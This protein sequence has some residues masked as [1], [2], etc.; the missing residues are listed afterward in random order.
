MEPAF[1]SP[2]PPTERWDLNR[3]ARRRRPGSA[4]PWPLVAGFIAQLL[5]IFFVTGVGLRELAAT[6]VRLRTLVDQHMTRLRLTHTMQVAV[7]ERTV[8]LARMVT[9]PDM[10]AQDEEQQLL[11]RQAE[12]FITARRQLLA[13][14]LTRQERALLD[15][16]WQLIRQAIPL[17]NQVIDLSLAGHQHQ[18]QQVLARETIPAQDAVMR[19]LTQLDDLIRTGAHAALQEATDAHH[20]A[21][22]WMLMLSAA[23]LALG[24]LIAGVVVRNIH[25]AN[26]ERERLATH[27]H[28]TGLPNR[29]LLLDRID[30]A[31]LRARRQHTQVGLLFIDLDGF[32][33]INDTLG[34]GVGDEMLKIIAQRLKGEVRAGD[35]VARLGGDEFIVGLLDASHRGQI[36]RVSQKLL[37]AIAQP[38]FLAGRELALSAS[39]GMCFFPD[40]GLDAKSLLKCAD[41]A[42][43]AAKQDGKNRVRRYSGGHGLTGAA[44][45]PGHGPLHA[46]AFAPN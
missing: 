2:R 14:P 22:R 18:A 11:S 42:M 5:L 19:T 31:I 43:Y 24:M 28:L 34:H 4:W 36:E 46:G 35:I 21:R 15:R 8:S 27:D 3:L 32:K 45:V 7:R 39:V 41:F 1:T 10:F 20:E 6:D 25:R 29:T 26:L 9:L 23:A 37:D 44:H 12:Y 16:Q 30:Q 40:D 17:Q 33:A 13:M 38:C